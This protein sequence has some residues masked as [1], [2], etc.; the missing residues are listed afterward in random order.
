MRVGGGCVRV[1][2][3]EGGG[4]G[5]KKGCCTRKRKK[6]Y[7]GG[8][9]KREGRGREIEEGLKETAVKEEECACVRARVC[10]SE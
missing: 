5:H 7:E 4:A 1:C 8:R 6:D 10:V 2:V 3:C 9:E